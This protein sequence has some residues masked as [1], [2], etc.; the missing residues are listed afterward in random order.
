MNNIFLFNKNKNTE[1]RGFFF[2][3]SF[4][5]KFGLYRCVQQPERQA[6]VV[7]NTSQ[8]QKRNLRI[9]TIKLL[10]LSFFG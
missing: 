10:T 7:V 5:N 9:E 6:T 1:K 8:L 3:L 4:L 2:F